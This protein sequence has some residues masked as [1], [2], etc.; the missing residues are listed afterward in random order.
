[1]ENQEENE[2]LRGNYGQCPSKLSLEDSQYIDGQGR[3]IL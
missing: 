1:M 2:S 3:L